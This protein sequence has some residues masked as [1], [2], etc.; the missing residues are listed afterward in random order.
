MAL[1]GGKL[2]AEPLFLF[3]LPIGVSGAQWPFSIPNN[4]ALLGIP[5]FTQLGVFYPNQTKPGLSA[6]LQM[7]IGT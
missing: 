2:L 5:V 7:M 4:N 6:G 3:T 1:F